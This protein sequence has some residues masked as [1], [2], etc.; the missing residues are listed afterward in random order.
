MEVTKFCFLNI[1]IMFQ[2]KIIINGKTTYSFLLN[3]LLR[4]AAG[5]ERL[6]YYITLYT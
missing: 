2:S 1:N 4:C 3:E 5:A 6:N